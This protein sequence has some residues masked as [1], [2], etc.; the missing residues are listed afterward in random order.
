L[1]VYSIRDL[2]KL[3]GIKAHTIRIWEQRY[4]LLNPKRT[5]T[6]IRYYL[7][8]DLKLLLNVALLNR[9]G[10]KISKIAKL[11]AEEIHKKVEELT[12]NSTE[13][14]SQV[15]ALTMAMIEMDEYK[16]DRIITANINHIGFERTII[17]II[18]PF[19]DK[20]SVLW[21]TGSV[22]PCQENFITCLIRQKIIA[23]IDSEP[24]TLGADVKKFVLFLP[25]NV[26]QELSLLLMQ[27]LIKSRKHRVIY[28]GNNVFADDVQKVAE[29]V[30]PDYFFTI[31]SEFQNDQQISKYIQELQLKSGKAE[32]LVTGIQNHQNGLD[33]FHGV[34]LLKSLDDTISFLDNM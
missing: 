17:E 3:S 18:H 33:E 26:N 21:L 13:H 14:L 7:E 30:N 32:V 28:L 1:S 10:F 31:I 11:S 6:N 29:I 20:L 15:D 27:Y 9:N 19:L 23:A 12:I 16:F 34:R 24:V 2:E 22:N 25:E 4:S 5:D 8:D